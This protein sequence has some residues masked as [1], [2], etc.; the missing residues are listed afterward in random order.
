MNSN[1]KPKEG[2]VTSKPWEW[3]INYRVWKDELILTGQKYF[4]DV[5]GSEIF[6]L[7]SRLIPCIPPWKSGMKHILYSLCDSTV[8]FQV[9][10]WGNIGWLAV[11]LLLYTIRAT[12]L[13]RGMQEPDDRKGINNELSLYL[14]FLMQ[15]WKR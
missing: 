1:L 3:P 14:Y 15:L 12:L 4:H 11:F 8:V 5:V 7:C 6:R 2:E 10:F 13:Q 9:L